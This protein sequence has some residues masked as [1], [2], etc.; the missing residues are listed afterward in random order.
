[1][2]WTPKSY[3]EMSAEAHT[4]MA[5]RMARPVPQPR[6][7][8]AP[9]ITPTPTITFGQF[10][11]G[12][13]LEWPILKM[14][15]RH[16]LV[17]GSTGYGKTLFCTALERD[18]V[19][20]GGGLLS[21]DPDGSHPLSKFNAQLQWID[22]CGIY[23]H[24]RVETCDLNDAKAILP[25][26]NLA[27]IDQVLASVI[28]DE[29]AIA[30]QRISGE[31]WTEKPLLESIMVDVLTIAAMFEWTICEISLLLQP[32]DE[33]GIRRWAI[34]HIQDSYL[35]ATLERLDQ[36]A[37]S[38]K[39]KRD[40]RA[41]TQGPLNRLSDVERFEKI[42]LIAGAGPRFDLAAAM[43]DGAIILVDAS[44]GNHVGDSAAKTFMSLLV[45]G[46]YST[47]RQRQH[48]QRLFLFSID[49]APAVIK[50]QQ[51]TEA[52]AARARKYGVALLLAS[53]FLMQT[54]HEQY[55]ALK[56]CAN[57]RVAFRAVDHKEAEEHVLDLVPIDMERA[58]PTMIRPTAV[59]AARTTLQSRSRSHHEAKGYSRGKHRKLL[60]GRR[61]KR[62][63]RRE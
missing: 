42:R 44:S 58:K 36:A 24:R 51:D 18:F 60:A 56:N 22:Q 30:F 53:Q 23:K 14:A 29:T 38:E 45:R 6:R 11:N 48:P 17:T 15:P 59:G 33:H 54:S 40:F 28:A 20:A 12:Q 63:V 34:E 31:D 10:E 5:E 32:D 21:V 16:T 4:R 52:L 2:P 13:M 49:E 37:V 27:A 35:R 9:P 62:R 55:L 7:L 39:S 1:M 47:M 43:D 8:P 50:G 26:N 25:F 57:T 46:I 41:M 19:L 3:E 61:F